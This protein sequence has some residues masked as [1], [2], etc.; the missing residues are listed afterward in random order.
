MGRRGLTLLEV[1]VALVILSVI[2]LGYLELFRQ[3]HRV[4]GDSHLW[5]RAVE[6][7]EDAMERAKLEGPATLQQVTEELP[8]G[9]RRRV[10]AQPWLPG[11]VAVE[12]TVALPGSGRLDLR[13]LL[14]TESPLPRGTSLETTDE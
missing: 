13:R 2:G 6:Y 3:S 8:G 14:Q 9:F 11:L 10:S 5:S 12:V 4:A 7:A 1:M